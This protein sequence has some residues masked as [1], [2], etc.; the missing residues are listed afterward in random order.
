MTLPEKL[1]CSIF[2]CC[3]DRSKKSKIELY[4]AKDYFSIHFI[5]PLKDEDMKQIKEIFSPFF[6]KN[7]LIIKISYIYIKS[8]YADNSRLLKFTLH[9]PISTST[10]TI[11]FNQNL[12]SRLLEFLMAVIFSSAVRRTFSFGIFLS[13]RSIIS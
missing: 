10:I 4:F 5:E 12:K 13:S 9:N 2:I 3:F 6:S 8:I 11:I 1:K 7:N